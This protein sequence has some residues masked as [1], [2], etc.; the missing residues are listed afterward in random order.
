MPSVKDLGPLCGDVLLFG[1]PY[2][3]LQATTAML[4]WADAK[5]I[6][7]TNRLCTGDMVAYCADPVA[8]LQMMQNRGGPVIAGNCEKQLADNAP[9]CGCGFDDGTTCSVLAK[10]WY[11]F[12]KQTVSQKDRGYMQGLPDWLVFRHSGKRYAVIHG[13]AS[14][15]SRFLWS[16]SPAA[17]LASEIY[18]LE[19]EIGAV[20]GVICGHSGLA[21][22]RRI[23]HAHWI[24]AGVIGMPPNDATR[25][26]EFAVLSET[27]LTFHRLAFDNQTAA[28]AMRRV[29]LTQGYDQAL[30]TGRWP[31]EDVLPQ[32]LRR[33]EPLRASG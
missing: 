22:D 21:F 18:N 2:S 4:D 3:N 14:T 33:Q 23:G 9:D 20:D 29:G 11:A 7:C 28:A 12:A 13:G 25:H 6:E 1:G 10:D 32:E 31:S 16:T 30:L 8:V 17:D 24:N 27:G 5:G 26:S 19:Q 15:I